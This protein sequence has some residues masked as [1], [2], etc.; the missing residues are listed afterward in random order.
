MHQRREQTDQ[1][2]RE[3]RILT[4]RF[5][6]EEENGQE[7]ERKFRWK[8][9]NNGDKNGDQMQK[10]DQE[11]GGGIE[12]SDDENEAEWRRVRYEREQLLKQ[13][14]NSDLVL[15]ITIY[16][17]IGRFI[18][19]LY[20]FQTT[21]QT[22]HTI[23]VADQTT[24]ISTSSKRISIIKPV[25]AASSKTASP[26]LITKGEINMVHHSRKSFLNRD[27]PILE[28]LACL[29]KPESGAI[30]STATGKGNYVFISTE[31]ND[32][33]LSFSFVRLCSFL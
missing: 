28:K 24:E 18:S 32:V 3:I 10:V 7:R 27:S 17:P 20:T 22:S 12:N 21:E 29:S 9:L 13:Q 16:V 25:G 26:F 14:V 6:E 8:H 4:E 11:D 5:I 1:D 31:K 2:A 19:K 30:L 15:N 23:E 33:I